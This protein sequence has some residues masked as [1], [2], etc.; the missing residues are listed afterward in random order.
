MLRGEIAGSNCSRRNGAAAAQ[1]DLIQSE[2][3]FM[4]D[5]YTQIT[6]QPKEALT[7]IS[8]VLELRAGDPQQRR[9]REHYFARIS[10]AKNARVLEVGCGTGAVARA[11]ADWPGV[12]EVVGVDPSPTL[13]QRARELSCVFEQ[14]TYASVLAKKSGR[15][16]AESSYNQPATFLIQEA[17]ASHDTQH[18]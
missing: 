4:P 2:I 16:G 12:G 18:N 14:I 6:T 17:L 10:F 1:T 5:I 13:L 15:N 8:Q 7:R 3:Q 9:M 11:L